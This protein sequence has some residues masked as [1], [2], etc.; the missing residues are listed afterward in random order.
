MAKIRWKTKKDIIEEE[1]RKTK[2]PSLEERI[3]V[4]EMFTLEQIL[5]EGEE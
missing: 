5:K 4:L 2:K 3:E 1:K